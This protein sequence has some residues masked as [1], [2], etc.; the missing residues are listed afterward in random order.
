MATS[1]E[2]ILAI[3]RLE[4]SDLNRICSKEHREEFTKRIKQWKAVGAALG[5]TQEHLESIDNCFQSEEKK[6]TVLL[7]QWIMR[8]GKEATYLKLAK[9]LFAGELLDVLRE[10]CLLLTTVATPTSPRTG[11]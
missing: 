2:E 1:L 6:K 8:D 3:H 5:F 10:L 7:F 11:Q 9:L 4:E